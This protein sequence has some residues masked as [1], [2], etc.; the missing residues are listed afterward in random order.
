[1]L[2]ALSAAVLLGIV[3]R[4]ARFVFKLLT[5]TRW[6]RRRMIRHTFD[7]VAELTTPEGL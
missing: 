5:A 7:Q 4:V 6:A 1:M 3:L 2:Y